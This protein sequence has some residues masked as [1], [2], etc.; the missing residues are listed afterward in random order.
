LVKQQKEAYTNQTDFIR[1]LAERKRYQNK[2][3]N[4]AIAE[5]KAMVNEGTSN[6]SHTEFSKKSE[7]DDLPEFFELI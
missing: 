6:L 1:D 4:H 7:N 3:L 2:E 5:V